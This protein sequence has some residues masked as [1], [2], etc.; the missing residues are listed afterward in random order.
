LQDLPRTLPAFT[1]CFGADA[2][3]RAYLV[4][5]SW[6]DGFRCS[7][8]GHAEA[9]SHNKRLIEGCRSCGRQHS[10]LAGTMFEQTKTGLSKWSLAIYLATSSKGGIPAMG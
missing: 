1:R 7:G 6:P 9:W 3:C 5:V 10:I 4:Q 2:K 8:C